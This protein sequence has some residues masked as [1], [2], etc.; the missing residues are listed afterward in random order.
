MKLS[1]CKY[2][3]R[4]IS[5]DFLAKE[6]DEH[7]AARVEGSTYIS[8]LPEY[9]LLEFVFYLLFGEICIQGEF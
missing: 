5:Y 2:S 7:Q 9:N 3:L 8:T 6:I 4:V 1:E